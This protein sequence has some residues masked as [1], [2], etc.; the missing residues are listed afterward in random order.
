MDKVTGYQRIILELLE[1]YA[2]I[3]FSYP[4]TLKDELIAD[5][6]RNHY[7]LLT[8]GWEDGRF[9]HEVFFHIDII[10][11]VLPSKIRYQNEVEKVFF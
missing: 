2:A 1:E 4:T 9:V 5:T 6:Q 3:P 11:G 10:D 7:Q 8:L